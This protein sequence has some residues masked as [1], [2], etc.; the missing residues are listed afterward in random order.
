VINRTKDNH[1]FT[2]KDIEKLAHVVDSI[3]YFIKM[4]SEM[5]EKLYESI[6][7]LPPQFSSTIGAAKVLSNAFDSLGHLA[8]ITANILSSKNSCKKLY[9]KFLLYLHS[10]LLYHYYEAT[11]LLKHSLLSAFTSYYSLAYSELRMSMETLVRG[12]IYD[13]L[14]IPR[15]RKNA[16]ELFKIKG[17][18]NA[19]GFPE[20]LNIINKKLGDNRPELSATILDIIDN[21]LQD[22]N[23]KSTFTKLISQLKAWSIIGNDEFEE[24]RNYYE[25]LSK[26]SH[27]PHPKFLDVGIR[28]TANKDWLEL[29]PVPGKLSE[30][31]I[32]FTDING[33]FAYLV[34]K[35]YYVDLVNSNYLKCINQEILKK[36]AYGIEELKTYKSWQ[37][38]KEIIDNIKTQA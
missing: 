10:A 36:I 13:L 21:E 19:K 34:L 6:E 5:M 28:I 16:E 35:T 14:A 12:L 11:M 26:Y 18:K 24:L 9:D 17:Y 27:R 20:L 15:Y 23:P 25:E 33:W 29:E 32:K 4:L 7:A 1:S 31:L 30:F 3:S 22:F 2:K 38:V 37:K 8:N